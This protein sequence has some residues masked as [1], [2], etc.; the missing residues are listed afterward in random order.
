MYIQKVDLYKNLDWRWS[1]RFCSH[2]FDESFKFLRKKLY[3]KLSEEQNL[4]RL[5]ESFYIFLATPDKVGNYVE[6]MQSGSSDNCQCH[7]NIKVLNLF[8]P[9]LQ[10]I[11]TNPVIKN[12]LKLFS[13]LKKF[14]LQSTLA[15]EYHKRYDL[16]IVHSSAKLISSGSDIDE[17]FKSMLQ[18]ITT[19]IRN[20][21][22]EYWVV[23]TTVKHNFKIF[24]V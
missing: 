10:L 19:K 13:D 6:M 24:E 9:E 23:E 5:D 1:E 18:S 17:A 14:K 2:K 20:S 12:K 21:A 22:S 15:L 7:C 11:N 3:S 4:R 8:D 16:K